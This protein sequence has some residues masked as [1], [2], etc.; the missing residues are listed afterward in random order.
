[1]MIAGPLVLVFSRPFLLLYIQVASGDGADES[2]GI[3][4]GNI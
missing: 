1:M 2:Q 4:E 3:I